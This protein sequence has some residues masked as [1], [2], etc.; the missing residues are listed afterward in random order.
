MIVLVGVLWG[1]ATWALYRSLRD[2]EQKHMLLEEQDEIDTYSPKEL[3]EL[4]DWIQ[5]NPS[6][7]SVEEA[8]QRY[9][10]CIEN[11]QR[12]DKTFYNWDDHDIESLEKI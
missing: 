6:D 12:I 4:K 2:E 10:E 5:A 3:A 8:R 1:V 9:N 7:E 11:P